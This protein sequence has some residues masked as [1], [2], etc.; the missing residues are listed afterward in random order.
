MPIWE[1]K[2]CITG[3]ANQGFGACPATITQLNYQIAISRGEKIPASAF[4]DF[5]AYLRNKATLDDPAKRWYLLGEFVTYEAANTDGQ[6][7]TAGNGQIRSLSPGFAGYNLTQW[8][9]GSCAYNNLLKFHL[10]QDRFDF[11]EVHG[12]VIVGA[13]AL[14]DT[15]ADAMK[16]ITMMQVYV[17]TFIGATGSEGEKYMIQFKVGNSTQVREG[18]TYYSFPEGFDITGVMPRIIDVELHGQAKSG[19][20]AGDYTVTA[21]TGCG[22]INLATTYAVELASPSMWVLTNAVTGVAITI[23]SVS[24]SGNAF[25]IT[26]DTADPDYPT[27]GGT[28]KLKMAAISVLDAAGVE[29]YESNSVIMTIG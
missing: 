5:P 26:A 7:E 11:L 8:D 2:D 12:N 9:G 4:T 13:R 6:T 19:T 1:Q 25:V 27:A 22:G 23:T 16:G 29:G 3:S 21:V 24:V 18:R 28:V 14:D 10:S 20:P 17:P 15:G